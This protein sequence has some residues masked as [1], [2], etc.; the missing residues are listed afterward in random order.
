M[1]YFQMGYVCD[2]F[3]PIQTHYQMKKLIL[4]YR[5]INIYINA[6]VVVN[7]CEYTT[8]IIN[9]HNIRRG[10][11]FILCNFTYGVFVLSLCQLTLTNKDDAHHLPATN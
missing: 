7:M 11:T 4:W 2:K 5:Y 3:S 6:H 10:Q 9:I 1:S 8:R